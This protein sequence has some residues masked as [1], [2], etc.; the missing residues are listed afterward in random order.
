MT[1]VVWGSTSFM[2]H[3]QVLK[4]QLKMQNCMQN[5]L[6]KISNVEQCVILLNNL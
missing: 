2:A 6:L 4:L 3:I 1:A 5:L